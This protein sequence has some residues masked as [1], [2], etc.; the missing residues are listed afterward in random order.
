MTVPFVRRSGGINYIRINNGIPCVYTGASGNA[1]IYQYT[2]CQTGAITSDFAITFIDE[3]HPLYVIGSGEIGGMWGPDIHYYNENIDP[4]FPSC[5]HILFDVDTP[6]VARGIYKGQPITEDPFYVAPTGVNTTSPVGCELPMPELNIVQIARPSGGLEYDGIS[7]AIGTISQSEFK[8]N[9]ITAIQTVWGSDFWSRMAAAN[10]THKLWIIR[11][12]GLS[13]GSGVIQSGVD[14]FKEYL[15]SSGIDYTEHFPTCNDT[16]RYLGWLTD[17]ITYDGDNV[18]CTGLFTPPDITQNNI[19]ASGDNSDPNTTNKLV[20]MSLEGYSVSSGD[21]TP[22]YYVTID[23]S[24]DSSTSWSSTGWPAPNG[25]GQ[26]ALGTYLEYGSVE[27][28]SPLVYAA[29]VSIYYENG[30]HKALVQA[31]C[32]SPP[33]AGATTYYWR[34]IVP[35]DKYGIP[36]GVLEP[37]ELELINIAN[38]GNTCVPRFPDIVFTSYT[39]TSF[40]VPS[41]IDCTQFNS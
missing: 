3:A 18:S 14:L 1:P 27:D 2:V 20:I 6:F 16:D 32:Y 35:L 7:E 19:Q 37:D 26:Y 9:I 39:P 38:T 13:M 8:D 41:G 23:E 31:D 21:L 34:S 33:L 10:G 30:L 24:V 15:A 29:Y 40:T 11:E 28:G 4:N 5:A 25:E 36:N 22:T 12:N 17:C